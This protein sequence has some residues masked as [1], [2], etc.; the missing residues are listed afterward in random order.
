[1]YI[2]ISIINVNFNFNM[3]FPTFKENHT[4]FK[5]YNT[6]AFSRFGNQIQT[7]SSLD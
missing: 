2:A 6:K 5:K 3:I 7:P 1:M 4:I